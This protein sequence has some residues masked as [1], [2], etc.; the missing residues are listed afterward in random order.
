MLMWGSQ[1]APPFRRY[2]AQ[3][4]TISSSSLRVLMASL[5]C[6]DQNWLVQRRFH[7]VLG[8]RFVAEG[9]LRAGAGW[10][11]DS[12]IGINCKAAREAAQPQFWPRGH[13]GSVLAV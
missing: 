4:A 13:L 2:S 11:L 7:F 9:R 1:L 5:P 3:V 8:W 6:A 12:A 10:A